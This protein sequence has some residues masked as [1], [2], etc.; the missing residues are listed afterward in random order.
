MPRKYERKT[1]RRNWNEDHMNNAIQAVIENRMSC[2]S[3][4][5]EFG[6]P[7]AT[8][9][10]YVSKRRNNIQLPLHGGRFRKTFS[11]QEEREFKEYITGLN[12]RAFGLTLLQFRQLAYQYAE[13]NSITH[14][15]NNRNKMAGKD[16]AYSFMAK[17][18][19]SMRTPESTSIG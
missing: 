3:A 2:N 19:L 10:R 8:L 18:K 15:F 16:W 11:E 13:I 9:R 4:S 6:I 1:S 17:Y 12:D 5:T 7:E 14:R